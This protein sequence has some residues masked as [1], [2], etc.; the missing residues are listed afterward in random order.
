MNY[1]TMP[2]GKSGDRTDYNRRMKEWAE[3]SYGIIIDKSFVIDDWMTLG[4]DATDY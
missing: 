3:K 4:P 1:G 2:I